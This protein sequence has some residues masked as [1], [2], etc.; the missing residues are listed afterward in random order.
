ML[1]PGTCVLDM[2]DILAS[3]GR[4]MVESQPELKETDIRCPFHGDWHPFRP[5][6]LRLEAPVDRGSETAEVNHRRLPAIPKNA[7]PNWCRWHETSSTWLTTRCAYCNTAMHVHLE[8]LGRARQGILIEKCPACHR[9]NAIRP[10]LEIDIWKIKG[11]EKADGVVTA[12]RV[13][14]GRVAW[15]KVLIK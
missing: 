11:K 3:I 12:M 5:N 13:D 8:V 7:G 15:Q 2:P 6:D 10:N 14:Q 4:D 9:E 1:K